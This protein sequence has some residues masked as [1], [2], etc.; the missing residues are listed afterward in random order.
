MVR[1]KIESGFE[2]KILT[3]LITNTRFCQEVLPMIRS[4][5]FKASY[6]REIHK[7]VDKFFSEFSCAPKQ[8]IK[9]I[10]LNNKLSLQD[11][12]ETSDNI[13]LLLKSLSKSYE[14]SENVNISF[15]ITQCINYLK[16]RALEL[17]KDQLED[18]IASNDPTKAESFVSNFKRVEKPSGQGIDLLH[19]H[20]KILEALTKEHN[21]IITFPGAVGTIIP[22][23]CRGDFMSFFGP[24]KR[25]KSF[26]LWY[27]A[28]I[29]MGQ[30][31]KVIYI[32][33]EMN[34]TAIIKR[35]WPSITGQ[36][37][38]KRIIH[39]AHFEANEDGKYSIE[40]DEKEM[41]GVN[42]ENIEDMQK[43]LRRLYRKGRI[44][45]IPMI[46]CTVQAIESLCDNLYYY[47][48][49]IPDTII[50]DYADYMEPG[51]KYTDNRDRI[52]TIWKGLR[53]FANERNVAIITAS[54]TEKKTFESDIKTS[55]ASEDIRKINHVTL[56]V[57]LNATDKE[58][59]DNIIRLGMMEVREGR[60]I[61]DQAVC[62]QCLDLGRPCIDSKMRKDVI[63]YENKNEE[64]RNYKRRNLE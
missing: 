26:W 14:E 17:L 57:A 9:D 53:D 4:S 22:P 15:E 21:E 28:E 1:E 38:Y 37:L 41:D 52:N 43:K 40:Q 58:N 34:D 11:D 8:H 20:N 18:S 45:I 50:I 48:N 12:E 64:K 36:P 27:S 54:H 31:N 23:I 2:R 33:L 55:Q 56:A 16:L 29:A 60:H 47:E 51:K 30:G 59:T 46:A 10:Y 35:C 32:P 6:S 62:L 63:G 39:S 19:D 5:Y 24:A 7:W 42:L 49:F 61:S 44:K 3:L 13:S 25:G